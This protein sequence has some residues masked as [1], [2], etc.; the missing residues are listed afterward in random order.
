MTRESFDEMDARIK[1]EVQRE[2]MEERVELPEHTK[3]LTDATRQLVH[4][5]GVTYQ[6][7]YD[8]WSGYVL[9]CAEA[10]LRAGLR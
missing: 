1:A 5:C 2:E 4:D 7:H 9:G 6:R 8:G 10:R 3:H